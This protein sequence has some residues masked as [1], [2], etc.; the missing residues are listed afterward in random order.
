[1]LAWLYQLL[2]RLLPE[3]YD[4]RDRSE[5]LET[6]QARVAASTGTTEALWTELRELVD[7]GS[8]VVSSRRPRL[9]L[10]S[11]AQDVRLAFRVLRQSPLTSLLAILS[12]ALG[13]GA[14]SAIY[15]CLDVFLF[16]PLPFPQAESLVGVAMAN[17]DQGWNGNVFSHRDLVDWREQADGVD[18]AGYRPNSSSVAMD[19]LAERVSSAD[20]SW[21]LLRVLRLQPLSGRG[22]TRDDERSGAR[23]ILVS[24][25]FAMR[26][27]GSVANA[28]G[29]SIRLD[30]AR[31]EV[32]G[33][34]P[35]IRGVP[36]LD[37]QIWLP[38][39]LTT[40][41]PRSGHSIYGIARLGENMT[42]SAAREHLD[43]VASAVAV[44]DPERTF[45][46]AR[47]RPFRD[48]VYG[49]QFEQGGVVLGIAVL[50]VLLIA[51]ANIANL[52]L[53]RGSARRRELGVRSALGAD[54]S[55]LVRQLLTESFVLAALGGLVGLLV[56]RAAI[57]L[58]LRFVLPADMPGYALIGLDQRV[59]VVAAVLT[60]FSA[61]AF[62]LAPAT[63]AAGGDLHGPVTSSARSTGRQRQRSASL[64]VI[65]E[66]TLALGLIAGCGLLIDSLARLRSVEMGLRVDDSLTFSVYLPSA[67]AT[68]AEAVADLH[69]QLEAA[70]RV[71]PGVQDVAAASGPA[72]GGW[73]TMLVER[74]GADGDARSSAENRVVTSGFRQLMGIE[75]RAGRWFNDSVDQPQSQQVAVVTQPLAERLWESPEAALG[76]RIAVGDT[77]W[78]V[79]GV[80]GSPRLRGP[81]RPPPPAVFR[82]FAQRPTRS[83]SYVV[84]AR[85]GHNELLRQIRHTVDELAPGLSVDRATTLRGLLG[86]QLTAEATSL[87][88]LAAM[89]ALALLLTLVGV[90]GVVA[91]AVGQRGREMG[92]RFALG[93]SSRDLVALVL[94]QSLWL[95]LVGV[96]AGIGV[97]LLLGKGL[98][99]FLSG[100]RPAN[101]IVL[102]IAVLLML[103]AV[104]VA[105]YP[106]ARRAARIDPNESL[107]AD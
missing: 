65:A 77:H 78:T 70:F 45:P 74:P 47:V 39:P 100:V 1:M 7:M 57:H 33:V 4:P 107:R 105:S 72:I 87:E 53:A 32:I 64:L 86:E 55:R 69:G 36:G 43:L 60:L 23:S 84:T 46:N 73:S 51:C 35:P 30:G 37:A 28:T 20:V 56:A 42:L 3:T 104:L 79:V 14:T 103:A 82:A 21:N 62:G 63:R 15:S 18:V 75:M 80:A 90:Y 101:P 91:H 44:A 38:L 93:A 88:L 95:A 5:I 68:D 26:A 85:G 67:V 12:L 52:L 31:Y 102:G 92:L 83:L 34:L 97:A 24:E 50:F 17:R 106:P 19:G 10:D 25:A 8:T 76:E 61:F 9:R 13:L 99:L 96:G 48:E 58:L 54:R 71:L 16:R 27:H 41:A 6:H 81:Q 29:R 40:D 98:T 66:I 22:F 11:L 49:A 94:R 59:V 2:V 89:A